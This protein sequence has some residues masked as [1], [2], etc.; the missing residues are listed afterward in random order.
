[1]YK[2]Y[3]GNTGSGKTSKLKAEYENLA[4][5]KGSEKILLF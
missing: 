4:A 3:S 5:E 1:M 2:I